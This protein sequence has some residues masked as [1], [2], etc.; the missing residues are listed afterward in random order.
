[1]FLGADPQ[2]GS[3]KCERYGGFVAPEKTYKV[4]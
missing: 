4:V 1:M 3:D 2:N